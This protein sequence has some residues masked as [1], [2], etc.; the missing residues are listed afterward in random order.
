MLNF[1]KGIIVGI[2]GIAPGLSGSVLLVILGL[3]HKVINA[4]GTLF[5]NFKKNV[6]FLLPLC[7]GFG[8]GVIIFS[9]I[10]D[11]FLINDEEFYKTHRASNVDGNVI[12]Y[13]SSEK[14][15]YKSYYDTKKEVKPFECKETYDKKKIADFF[16]YEFKFQSSKKMI[17][18]I[19][20]LQIGIDDIKKEAQTIVDVQKAAVLVK[21][22]DTEVLHDEK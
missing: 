3:Y 8:V 21:D 20:S 2:G 10:V 6:I 15:N 11:F 7:L 16:G 18:D 17:D 1:L 5:K 12:D 22:H 13:I 4:I 14:R 19:S 9:K